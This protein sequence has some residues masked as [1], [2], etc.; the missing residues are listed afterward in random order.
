MIEFQEKEPSTNKIF[1]YF[2]VCFYLF[3]L[4]SVGIRARWIL[5]LMAGGSV[6]IA[7]MKHSTIIQIDSLKKHWL[8]AVGII[9]LLIVMPN[10]RH[11]ADIFN[12][13]IYLIIITTV[14]LLVKTDQFEVNKVF[15]L[16]RKVSLLAAI[17]ISFFRIFSGLYFSLVL[18]RLAP[19]VAENVAY[20]ARF[21]YGVA[22]GNSYTFGDYIIMMGIATFLADDIT[23]SGEYI[24]NKVYLIICF[25]GI[26]LEGRK[27][28]LF[29]S[30]LTVVIVFL[31]CADFSRVLNFGKKLFTGAII[32]MALIMAIPVMYQHGLLDRFVLLLERMSASRAGAAVDFTS[33][34]SDLWSYA[35]KLFIDYPFL[36]RGWGRFANYTTGVFQQTYEAQAVRDVHNCLLQ[37]LCETGG[38]GTFLILTP[39]FLAYKEIINHFKCLKISKFSNVE[40]S[41]CTIYAFTLMT[42][43]WILS[44]MDPALYNHYFWCILATVFIMENASREIETMSYQ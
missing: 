16:I 25:A 9:L 1:L 44:L 27:S 18:P 15:S 30:L 3:V 14:L 43:Y 4:G 40:S 34:R 33:G 31:T 13:A 41:T 22:L 37:L 8:I 35:I 28:E 36:G 2:I 10:A 12:Q 5:F 6:A 7:L 20:N 29:A 32:I 11:E 17:Y 23:T 24:K 38:V 42:F 21:G 26:L 19:S 39:L